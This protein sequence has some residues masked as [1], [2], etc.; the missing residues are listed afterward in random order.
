M[1]REKT[2]PETVKLCCLH[3]FLQRYVWLTTSRI[4]Q[5]QEE[6]QKFTFCYASPLRF[7]SVNLAITRPTKRSRRLSHH[8]KMLQGCCPTQRSWEVCPIMQSSPLS[9]Q[10]D[11]AAFKAEFSENQECSAWS[12]GEK[13][14]SQCM[15]KECSH[16]LQGSAL[17]HLPC[18]MSSLGRAS[19]PLPQFPRLAWKTNGYCRN[20][21]CWLVA[22]GQERG[23]QQP[24][25]W[26]IKR[27]WGPHLQIHHAGPR[28]ASFTSLHKKMVFFSTIMFARMKKWRSLVS[29][30]SS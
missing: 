6:V 29:L 10:Q 23:G 21:W 5:N 9:P 2:T 1:A 16:V 13:P 11:F 8:L 17:L 15:S 3:S 25:K 26:G 14:C 7:F 27:F 12:P 19:C 18:S 20:A 28:A 24:T 30:S 22:R 4:P